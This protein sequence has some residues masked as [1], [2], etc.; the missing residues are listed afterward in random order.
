[1]GT[2]IQKMITIFRNKEFTHKL[3]INNWER[4]TTQK[5]REIF[6]QFNAPQPRK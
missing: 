1:M 3:Q 6:R 2:I 4:A 5:K